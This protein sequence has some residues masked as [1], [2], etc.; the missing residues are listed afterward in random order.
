M[1]GIEIM[2]DASKSQETSDPKHRGRIQA[3]EGGIEKSIPW[4]R[5]SPPTESGMLEMCDALEAQ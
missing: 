4:A 2:A 1:A 3:Q 5:D